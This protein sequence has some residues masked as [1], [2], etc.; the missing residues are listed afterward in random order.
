MDLVSPRIIDPDIL[1]LC[2]EGN[3]EPLYVCDKYV[4]VFGTR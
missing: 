1:K 4:I 3:Y 2:C